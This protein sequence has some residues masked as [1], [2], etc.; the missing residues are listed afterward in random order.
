M[1]LQK[2]REL[3]EDLSFEEKVGQLTQVAGNLYGQDAI[4]TGL[5]DYFKISDEALDLA[6]SVLSIHGAEA[7][8]K[9]QKENMEKQPHHIPQIFMYDIINGFET[10]YP[11]PLGQGA[12]F[13]PE[14]VKKCAHMAGVEGAAAGLHV[15]F[16]PMVDLVRDARWGRVMES[17]GEDPYLNSKLGVAMVEGYQGRNIQEKGN[18]AACVKHFAAY[19]GAEA[20]RDYDNVELSERT[21]RED[22]LPAYEACI[23]AGAKLVMTSFNTL[24]RVPSSG[25][26]WLMR[27]V[28]REEMGFDGVL[29]SDYGAIKEMINHGYSKDEKQAGEQAMKA[30]VD[31]EMMSSAYVRYLKEL[32]EEGKVDQSLIDEC[33]WRV[34]VLKNELGLFENP[35]KDASEEDEQRLLLCEEHRALAREAAAKS[36]VVLKNEGVLPLSKEKSTKYA[37]VGPYAV[38]KEIYGSWSFPSDKE[39]VISI[40]EGVENAKPQAKCE[41]APGCYLFDETFRLKSGVMYEVDSSRKE[42]MLKEAIR[43]AQNAETVIVCVGEHSQQTGEA[44]ARTVLLISGDQMELLRKVREVNDNVVTLVFSGRM[45]ELEE[46]SKLSKAVVYAWF[47]GTEGGNAI[48][49]VLFGEKEPEGRLP[50]SCSYRATQLPNYYNRFIT[51]RPNDGTLNQG[52]V[53]GY[54][55]QVDKVLYPFGYGLSYTTFEYSPVTLDKT[56][57]SKNDTIT[58]SVTLTNTGDRIGTE[59]VQLYIQDLFGNV[60]RP[61]RMLKGFEKVTLSPGESRVVSFQITEE[62]LRFWNIDMEYAS[63][64]GDFK[65]SIGSD[66][67]CQNTAE[68][69]LISG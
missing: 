28:L 63:E 48:A 1:E 66:S 19:G 69:E 46:I 49:D 58:A 14:L 41:F 35:Y 51:G 4:V 5:L 45:L 44:A 68:F 59:T 29:I 34:L 2:L 7:L 39:K 30:G 6:G 26:K 10:I 55:D 56:K 65:V 12:T 43:A 17:T 13:D 54:I 50:M 21:L 33:V 3:M 9:L 38:E 37:F 16:S 24:N 52:F 57:M 62:M 40:K 20:G 18:L 61:R 25:N 32:V 11:V 31:I 47:P 15:T 53:M 42:E 36:L 64:E 8:K 23:K 27:K 22:Y 67:S 60:V